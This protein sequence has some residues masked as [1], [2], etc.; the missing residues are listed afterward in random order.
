MHEDELDA[1]LAA[2]GHIVPSSGFTASVMRAVRSDAAVPPP[3][4]F[5]WKV[6][7][8]GLGA[9]VAV[10]IFTLVACADLARTPG[11]AVKFAWMAQR[12]VVET[13]TH[14]GLGWIALALLLSLIAISASM[15][16]AGRGAGA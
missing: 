9:A 2:E 6:A 11:L 15:R 7:L 4:P 8:P 5:P 10:V 1:I 16:I 12:E 3:I 13:A 14:F